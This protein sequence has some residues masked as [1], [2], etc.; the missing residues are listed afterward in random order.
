MMPAHQLSPL[1]FS[2]VKQ[3]A[4][5]DAKQTQAFVVQGCRDAGEPPPEYVLSELIGK[6]SFGR[7][8]KATGTATGQ[9]VAVKIIS[10]EEGDSIQPGAAD[11]FGDILKEVNTL[12][13]LRSSGARNINLIIDALLVGQSVWMVTEFCAGG[14]VAS[15]IRPTGGLPEKWIIPILREVAEALHWVHRQ[16]IIHRDIKCANVLVSDS[17]GVQICD[18]GVAGI[19]QS[20]FDKRS[21]ITGTLHWMAPELFDSTV[22]YG[23]EVDIWAFG[24][25]AYEVASGLPPNA[26]TTIN[27]PQFGS[28]LKQHCPRL[29]GDQYSRGLKDLVALCMVEEPASRPTID[30]VQEHPYLF[31]TETEH[32]T[33]SLSRLVAAYR[34]WEAQGGSRR[35]LFSMGGAQAVTDQNSNVDD[36]DWDFDATYD[37]DELTVKIS[38]NSQASQDA[39]G[40]SDDHVPQKSNHQPRRRKRQPPNMTLLK[41]PLQKIFEPNTLS[42][43]EDNSRVFYGRADQPVTSDQPFREESE[44]VAVRE[45]L[46]D[47]DMALDGGD[48]SQFTQV[49]TIRARSVSGDTTELLH[50]RTQD[51]SFP[52]TATVS[53]S[54]LGTAALRPPNTSP[55]SINLNRSSAAR[56]ID[57]DAGLDVEETGS[58]SLG[59]ATFDPARGS[60]ASLIDLDAS[61][62]NLVHPNTA[63]SDV[64]STD[65]EFGNVHFTLE[66]HA[67]PSLSSPR[68]PSLYVPDGLGLLSALSN[69]EH[70]SA[71]ESSTPWEPRTNQFRK[72]V[73]L[74]SAPLAPSL[75]VMQGVAPRE[76]VKAE[77]QNLVLSLGEHLQACNAAVK[78]LPT[79]VGE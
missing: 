57:L 41:A 20:K 17:G 16:G 76:D 40:S 71:Q 79:R 77:L 33:S 42:K 45:S 51:W 70:E 46:I 36:D 53:S 58:N 59:H 37:F 49:D 7:V 30:R 12:R 11:T 32:P 22:S 27:I 3:K 31:N 54:R 43:Y 55:P 13:L 73:C 23:V 50:R 15:L 64:T 74:P 24:S 10:I 14:S 28:Y 44:Q 69:D 56:L 4:I 60:V 48:L 68:E 52:V 61:L 8:Y 66:T 62:P 65:S 75:D 47:L 72:P 1:D 29:E 6:G 78:D 39:N 38:T 9:L 25:M 26:T 5:E 63:D 19:I 35:S 21:T 34:S 18:F 2:D 67:M